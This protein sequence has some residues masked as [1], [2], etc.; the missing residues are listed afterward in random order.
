MHVHY[1]LFINFNIVSVNPNLGFGDW[2]EGGDLFD[3]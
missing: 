1:N 2:G 3:L